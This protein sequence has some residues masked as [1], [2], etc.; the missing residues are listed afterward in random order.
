MT[1]TTSNDLDDGLSFETLIPDIHALFKHGHVTDEALIEK[2]GKGLSGDLAT[3]L[4]EGLNVRDFRLRLSAI[5]TPSCKLFFEMIDAP[6]ERL[7]ARTFILF[8]YGHILEALFMYLAQE[9]GHDVQDMQKEIVFEGIKGHCD[10]SID[11]VLVDVKSA[12]P[13]GFLKFKDGSIRKDDSFNY[14]PQL[15]AYYQGD[16]TYTKGAAFLAINKVSGDI[17][18]CF[19]SHEE[20]MSIDVK[21]HADR[22]KALV[23][24]PKRPER[25]FKPVPEGKSGN[26]KLDTVCS[27]CHF[28]HTCWPN[29][30]TFAY[31]RGPVYLTTVKREP[32]TFELEKPA[33][34]TSKD[35]L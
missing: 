9:A 35:N 34:V 4:K 7:P 15:A 8:Q 31:S 13:F 19:F 32:K 21:A 26:M 27:Y 12:S 24:N 18:S 16:G 30:R 29:L 25:C 5:G 1:T 2:F 17:C 6:R 23:A 20:M 10:G 3:S 28:K 33:L 22:Q 14:I 11:G